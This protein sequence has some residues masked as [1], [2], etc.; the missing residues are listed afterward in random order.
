MEHTINQT[1]SQGHNVK[2]DY[3]KGGDE[4]NSIIGRI[5]GDN[6]TTNLY[7]GTI[8]NLKLDEDDEK[9]FGRYV[10]LTDRLCEFKNL[11]E[12]IE[13]YCELYF[14]N[15]A[16]EL[17]REANKIYHNHPML[18]ALHGLCEY[19]LLDKLELIRYPEILSKTIKLFQKLEELH[20]DRTVVHLDLDKVVGDHLYT[21]IS[22]SIKGIVRNTA[23]FIT[24]SK[25]ISY[26]KVIAKYLIH[27]ENCYEI[28]RNTKYL[29]EYVF[30][31]SGHRSYAWFMKVMDD[32]IIDH[33]IGIF[34]GGAEKHLAKLIDI[35]KKAEP[36]YIPPQ[37]KYGDY[38]K[39]PKTESTRR[40]SYGF[41]EILAIVLVVTYLVMISWLLLSTSI[42]KHLIL[43]ILIFPPI[44]WI[45][46]HPFNGKISLL[47]RII[48]YF[49]KLYNR[50]LSH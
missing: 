21:F 40:V 3:Y 37:V 27:Y 2:G 13:F 11:I 8:R 16:M 32:E 33:G 30:H 48:E 15:E 36:N 47:Q 19:A 45:I 12:R 44:V 7:F 42:P 9:N 4:V 1:N 38:F 49:Y 39:P 43:L 41:L 17:I 14:F 22:S 31:L 10:I 18:L 24:D 28:N 35:I 46:S 26:Y 34:E 25:A 6:N 5:E 20:T 29:K 50:F 23:H